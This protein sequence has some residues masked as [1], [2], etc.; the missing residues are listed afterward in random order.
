MPR[1]P[2]GIH[3]DP[4]PASRS[5]L[6]AMHGGSS[7]LTHYPRLFDICARLCAERPLDW[8]CA[9]RE[10]VRARRPQDVT[11][12]R[13]IS[14]QLEL[15]GPFRRAAYHLSLNS[16]LVSA[17]RKSP[18]ECNRNTFRGAGAPSSRNPLL[19]PS[20]CNLLLDPCPSFSL[21]LRRWGSGEH[22][23]SI[24]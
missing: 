8:L 4:R 10:K 12:R 2:F 14:W 20:T 21:A 16:R 9:P 17:V 5:A 1:A 6:P 22:R 15:E 7:S 11:Q 3:L 24:F 19:R 13:N 23:D 18:S